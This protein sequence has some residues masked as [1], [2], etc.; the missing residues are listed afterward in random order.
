M[1][2][3]MLKQPFFAPHPASITCQR[4]IGADNS[5]TWHNNADIIFT[6]RT[7]NSPYSFSLLMAMAIS[8]YE[9]VSP[10]P[11]LGNACHTAC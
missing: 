3:L 9:A 5:M 6:I 8:L 7:A 2:L 10:K 11:T 1:C 4:S